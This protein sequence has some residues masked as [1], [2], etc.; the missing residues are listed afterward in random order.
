MAGCGGALERAIG[1]LREQPGRGR[2]VEGRAR[3]QRHDG[4]RGPA[5]ARVPRHPYRARR[6][7][8]PPRGSAPSSARTAPGRTSTAGRAICRRRSRRGSP[9]GSRATRLTR[10]IWPRPRRG[11]WRAGGVE[12]SRVFTRIWLALFGLW[13]WDELPNLPPEIIFLPRWFPFNVLRLGLLGPADDRPAHDRDHPAA[14]AAAA[15]RASTRSAPARPRRRCCPRARGAAS[16]SG[17]TGCCTRTP[18]GRSGRLRRLAMRRAVRLDRRPAGG[19]RGM[20]RH[21]AA[22]GLLAARARAVRAS[23]LDSPGDGRGHPGSRG[24]PRPRADA[25]RARCAGSRPA[26]RRC[27]TPRWR[28]TACSTR[29]SDPRIRWC[30]ARRAGSS[31]KRSG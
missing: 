17:S 6:P 24:I 21:P 26:S 7:S 23:A 18:S 31:P 4:R 15:R 10:P 19:R 29:A 20:G 25:R 8:R 30:S 11:S 16:S 14:A 9:C 1:Y 3:D 12:S 13:S 27:G 5:A 22:V 2:L 28:S